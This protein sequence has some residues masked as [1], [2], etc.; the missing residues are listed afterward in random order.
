MSIHIIVQLLS[1]NTAIHN[2]YLKTIVGAFANILF[3]LTNTSFVQRRS[4]S[5]TWIL[6]AMSAT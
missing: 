2:M 1:D 5:H 4:S 3:S 6:L